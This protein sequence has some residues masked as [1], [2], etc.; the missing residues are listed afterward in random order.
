MKKICLL[1]TISILSIFL[2]SQIAFP[3]SLFGITTREEI[4]IGKRIAKDIEKNLPIYKDPVYQRRLDKVGTRLSHFSDRKDLEYNFQ[5]IDR[6]ELNAFATFGGYIYI[7]KGA[8]DKASDDDELAAILAHEIAHVS[9][10]HLSKSIEQNRA[11]GLWFSLLDYFLLRK[12]ESRRDIHRFISVGYDIMQRG[13]SRE[14]ELEADRLGTR[15]SYKARYNSFAAIRILNKLKKEQNSKV[16]DPFVNIG[17]LR[18]HPYVDERIDEVLSEI[19][20][21]KAEESLK[22]SPKDL[23]N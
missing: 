3:Q 14:D 6:E 7:Y 10:K 23:S 11:F 15:F 21:I 20:A 2:T 5:I 16:I 19:A 17:I 18:T 12:Q 13:Y 1:F 8:M 4:E 22:K 9:A